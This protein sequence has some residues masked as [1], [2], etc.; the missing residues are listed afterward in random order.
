MYGNL[1]KLKDNTGNYAYPI[2]RAEG[3]F[4]SDNKTLKQAIDDGSLGGG[5]NTEVTLNGRNNAI[6]TLR[7]PAIL[8]RKLPSTSTI[9]YTFPNVDT[10]RGRRMFIWT[11]AGQGRILDLPD[12]QLVVNEALIYNVSTNTTR[13]GTGSWGNVSVSTN[14]YILLYN[15]LGGKP[16]GLFDKYLKDDPDYSG[17]PVKEIEGIQ[18]KSTG[19]VQGIMTMDNWVIL[20]SHSNDE[21]TDFTGGMSFLNKDTML[22]E[23]SIT[24]NFG[25]MNAPY[26]NK[27]KDIFIVGN[28]SKS[29]T[30]TPKGWIVPNFSQRVQEARSI[31]R[32]D[33]HTV[34]KVELDFAH[35][36]TDFKG[37]MCWGA[38]SSDYIWL[39]TNDNTEFRKVLLG[40]GTNNL[41]LG[42]F[43][44][45]VNAT[46][47]NGSYSIVKSY[48]SSVTDVMGG[49]LS[50]RG[51]IYTGIKGEYHIRKTTPLTNGYFESTYIIIPGMTGDIQGIAILD[52]DLYVFS[53]YRGFKIPL[54]ELMYI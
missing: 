37:Q 24:H 41:G 47:Y 21:H 38:D 3:V 45:G 16:V 54:S 50:Y 31:G 25:H 35:L 46:E 1:K 13:I 22:Q 14:E 6:I 12:G 8:W 23:F 27:E 5:D 48:Y 53:D 17:I 15:S 10:N 26:Y 44:E 39:M 34:P 42:T 43:I 18:V 7:N 9:S 19:S 49:M 28:G 51:S 20:T 4:I 30:L 2:T 11:G 33:F 29:Y 52:E 36:T 32:L 40:K